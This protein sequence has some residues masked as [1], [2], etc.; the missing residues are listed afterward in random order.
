M[1]KAFVS[2]LV[3]E[4]FLVEP[5]KT[6]HDFRKS[7]LLICFKNGICS[8]VL[9]SLSFIFTSF[10]SNKNTDKYSLRES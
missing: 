10:L 2:D 3:Y 8:H 7:R 9:Q 5:S 1:L 4:N 6:T